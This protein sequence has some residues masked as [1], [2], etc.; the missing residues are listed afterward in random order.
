LISFAW[1]TDAL[2]R[3]RKT[4]TRRLGW[5]HLKPGDRLCAVRQAMGLK[6]GQTVQRLAVIEVVSTR[7]ESMREFLYLPILEKDAEVQRE[8]GLWPCSSSFAN[9]LVGGNRATFDTPFTRIEFRVVTWLQQGVEVDVCPHGYTPGL[10]ETCAREG[11][12]G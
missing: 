6:K 1:T 3:G 12:G 5:L 8:G 10:C 9:A 2:L 4:V 11:E 7:R